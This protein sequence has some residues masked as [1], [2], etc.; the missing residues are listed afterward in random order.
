MFDSSLPPVVCRRIHVLFMLFV[1]VCAKLCPTYIVLCF[2]FVF[3]HL[4]HE[5]SYIQP[6]VKTNRTSKF[7]YVLF[8][9]FCEH[10]IFLHSMFTY[11]ACYFHHYHLQKKKFYD[12]IVFYVYALNYINKK[13]RVEVRIFN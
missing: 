6:E 2:C 4:V 9:Y 10:C 7:C 8:L 13:M 12:T 3:L 1:F 5:S 11:M